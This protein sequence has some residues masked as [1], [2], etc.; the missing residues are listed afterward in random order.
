MRRFFILLMLITSSIFMVE[1]REVSPDVAKSIARGVLGT[2]R[3][4]D[5]TVAWDSSV[6]GVTRSANEAPTFYV[7]T[8][9]SGSGFVIVAG[10]DAITPILAYSTHYPAPSTEVLPPN[11]K[12]WLRYVDSAVRYAREHNIIADKA[13]AEKWSE[14]YQP[15]AATML[16]TARWH[17]TT[18]YNNECPID[19]DAHSLTGCTQTALATIMYHN[20]WP[21]RAK[22]VTEAYTTMGGLEVPARDLNHAY[23]WENMLES[24]VE[25]EYNDTQAKAVAVLMADIGHAFKANYT[26]T[27]T[28]AFPDMLTLYHKFGY[29][30]ASNIAIRKIYSDS[31]WKELLRNEIDANRPIFY[32]GYTSDGAGHAFVLDGVDENDYFHVNWGWGGYYDG[33]FLIDNLLLDVYLFDT[34]QWAILGMHP[35]RNGEI[36]NWLCLVSSGM[37]LSTTT[38]ERGVPFNIE[39]ISIGNYSQ[40]DFN[41]D[42]RVGVCDMSGELKSWVIEALPFSLPA[43]YVNSYGTMTAVIDSEI[44]EGDRL[45]AFYRASGSDKWFKMDSYADNACDEVVLKYAPI[46]DTTSMSFDKQTG[47]LVVKYDDDVKSALYKSGKYVETGV[48]ITKGR[49]ILDT[50][51]LQRDAAYTIYLERKDI[52]QKSITFTLKGL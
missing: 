39:A 6:L 37:K 9:E 25:G 41:G 19:G 51:Q 49:M 42:I 3:S 7:V 47:L 24:Y 28:G 4:G 35:L 17:Q 36:D 23:D 29:S 13:T 30:P 12:G 2:T 22:G 50:K 14:E 18:P 31:Y 16:N 5:V 52:E 33:F 10:D 34:E 20:R 1:A 27:D 48:L 15:V 40:L 45:A 43:G 8:S 21:E 46:G 32:A 44:L 11:F 26:A 38:F